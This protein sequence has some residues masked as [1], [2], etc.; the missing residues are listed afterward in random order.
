[1]SKWSTKTYELIVI[2]NRNSSAIDRCALC[3][4][5]RLWKEHLFFCNS[6]CASVR[7]FHNWVQMSIQPLDSS[8]Y[9][10]AAATV[11]P[12]FDF[13]CN[14]ILKK[15]AAATILLSKQIKFNELH[16]CLL[17]QTIESYSF[18]RPYFFCSSKSIINT[19]SFVVS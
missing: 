12:M 6:L 3:S 18:H 8:S 9:Y 13:T 11:S 2:D 17:T 7:V 5:H 4:M 19:D 16:V 15:V 14:L 1:M 10:I